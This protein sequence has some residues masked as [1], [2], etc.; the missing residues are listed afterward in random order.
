ME[1][2]LE[3]ILTTNSLIWLSGYCIAILCPH[4]KNRRTMMFLKFISDLLAGTYLYLIGGTSGALG[5]IIAGTGAAIQAV[6]PEKYLSSSLIT[7]IIIATIL[8]V[9]GG[10]LIYKSP[11]DILPLLG[12][13]IARFG[14]L[15][16]STQRIR[17]VYLG[18]GFL[19]IIYLANGTY[20]L[21][22]VGATSRAISTG[23]AILRYKNS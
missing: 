20:I 15:Q 7:R 21:P 23:T 9:T 22:L 6:T 11:V 5:C 12:V 16:K 18:T 4:V 14:E 1:N 3:T 17:Y 8:A 10:V 19:W 13:V 2:L